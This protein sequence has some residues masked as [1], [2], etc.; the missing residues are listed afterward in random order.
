[1]LYRNGNKTAASE[2][3]RFYNTENVHHTA[4]MSV[5]QWSCRTRA[6]SFRTSECR[7]YQRSR[8][9]RSL[10][11]KIKT[12][13]YFSPSV[14]LNTNTGFEFARRENV[15]KNFKGNENNTVHARQND[16]ALRTF[17]RYCHDY[18]NNNNNNNNNNRRETPVSTGESYHEHGG[19]SQSR[20]G[21]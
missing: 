15:L 2:V 1:V 11:L 16:T 3:V 19:G 14:R 8:I 20:S 6:A 4:P 5:V 21:T 9:N 7:R 18:N 13:V 12:A 17:R 10:A